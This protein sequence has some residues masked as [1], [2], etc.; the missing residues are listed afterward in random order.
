MP[1]FD[2]SELAKAAR[3]M[4]RPAPRPTRARRADKRLLPATRTRRALPNGLYA[5]QA[6]FSKPLLFPP[7]PGASWSPR[8]YLSVDKHTRCSLA[9]VG[10]WCRSTAPARHLAQPTRRN[11]PAY[12]FH[13]LDLFPFRLS[14]RADKRVHSSLYLCQR[15]R[16]RRLLRTSTPKVVVVADTDSSRPLGSGCATPAGPGDDPTGSRTSGPPLAAATLA[17]GA[18]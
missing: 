14:R 15:L 7:H 3:I 18:R 9:T 10:I 1:P 8:P 6:S 4:F 17:R 5:R 12:C 11:R 2:A 13:W 16:R